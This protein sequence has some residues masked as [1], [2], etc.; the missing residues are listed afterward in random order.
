MTSLKKLAKIIHRNLKLITRSK[1]SALIVVF[2][3]LLIILLVGAAF[4][5]SNVYD[6]I[7]GVYSDDYSALSQSIMEELA[8]K[9]FSVNKMVSAE[10]CISNI[11]QG[12]IHVC[13]T[14]P[15]GLSVDTQGEISFY[16]DPSRV[17]LVYAV[18]EG[19][20]AKVSTKSEQLSLQLAGNVVDT[21][22]SAGNEIQD[23]NEIINLL[24]LNNRELKTGV[25]NVNQELQRVDLTYD[26]NVDFNDIERELSSANSNYNNSFL[27]LGKS[28]GRLKVAIADADK[29]IGLMK[30]I[31]YTQ[32]AKLDELANKLAVAGGYLDS[33]QDSFSLID[34][35]VNKVALTSASKIVSPIRTTIKPV[36]AKSTNLNFLFPTLLVIVVMFGSIMLSAS[37][38]IREKTG[39]AYFRNFITPTKEYT[40]ILGNFI[41]NLLIVGVQIGVIFLAA[42]YYF[43]KD[44]LVVLGN[45]IPLVLVIISLFILIGMFIGYIFRT[46]ETGTL[47]SISV[48]S[49][50]LFFSNALLPTE[51]LPGVF[52]D[53]VQ[54]NPFILSESLLRKTLIFQSK[55]GFLLGEISVMLMFIAIIAVFVVIVGMK[56]KKH[57]S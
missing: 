24:L 51:S 27:D 9:Q 30:N 33:L 36:V 44:L 53:I 21:L 47:A 17:N 35:E 55:I 40:F 5:T 3:P 41:T 43:R 29:K 50:M 25:I 56:S 48:S 39:T 12:K 52:K 42:S 8:G 19:V 31:Q 15:A 38:V 2:G 1:S 13:I 22:K 45:L 18:M 23:N 37:I 16:V 26:H 32:K 14:F 10:D 20:S 4:N 54:F 49:I 6:I 28:L 46:Q 34:A 11:K 57:I 7:V